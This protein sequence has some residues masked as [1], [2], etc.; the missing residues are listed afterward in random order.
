MK[1]KSGDFDLRGYEVVCAQFFASA[2]MTSVSFSR[3]GIRFSST[4]IRKFINTEYV[5][6]HVHPNNQLIAALPCSKHHKNKM[7]WARVNT[8]GFSVRTISGGAFLKTLYELFSWDG[9]KRYRLRGE[10]VQTDREIIALFDARKPEIFTSRYDMAIPWA[11]GFG[12]DYYCYREPRLPDIS[13]V[14]TFTE[15]DNEPELQ[16]TTPEAAND[17][18]QSLMVKM[19][20]DLS[21]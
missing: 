3:N 15:Y 11:T 10:V 6:L 13:I 21:H 18:I 14:D 19:Q 9:D 5:E 12:E 2:S 7:C 4:C 8:D 17:N 1:I 16:P 20:K